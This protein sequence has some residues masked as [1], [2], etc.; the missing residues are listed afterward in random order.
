MGA[1]K[2]KLELKDEKAKKLTELMAAQFLAGIQFCYNEIE[3]LE[4]AAREAEGRELTT[5]E[6]REFLVIAI[7]ESKKGI[8]EL[9]K[10]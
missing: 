6:V 5:K 9:L 4:N 10:A 2:I 1:N 8:E 3:K 7:N